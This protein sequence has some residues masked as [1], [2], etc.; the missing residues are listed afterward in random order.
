MK[1]YYV[2]VDQYENK[3]SWDSSPWGDGECLVD[4]EPKSFTLFTSK[5]E[6]KRCLKITKDFALSD[7]DRE[8]ADIWDVDS[9][10]IEEFVP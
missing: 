8:L 3:L 7:E 2:V 9:W 1:K 6:A 5:K 10:T 4:C